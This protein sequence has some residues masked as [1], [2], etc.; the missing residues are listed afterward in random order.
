[1]IQLRL[2]PDLFNEQRYESVRSNVEHWIRALEERGYKVSAENVYAA[3]Q[4][5]SKASCADWLAPY[6]NDERNCS[7]LLA[8]LEP[9]ES[10][11]QA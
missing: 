3:W 2:K 5:H 1:M 11:P 6:E 4:R 9:D 10:E 7:A 8:E